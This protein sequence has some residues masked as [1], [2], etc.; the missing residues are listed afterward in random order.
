MKDMNRRY[1]Q[2]IKIDN[3][4]TDKILRKDELAEPIVQ[5]YFERLWNHLC[6]FDKDYNPGNFNK[7]Y[8]AKNPEFRSRFTS[9]R[10]NIYAMCGKVEA[11]F[12]ARG[13]VFTPLGQRKEAT[14][15]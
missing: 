9:L 1:E 11:E 15:R 14:A 13:G 10:D 4:L 7:D 12:K 2:I 5:E 6:Q 3:W 8:D